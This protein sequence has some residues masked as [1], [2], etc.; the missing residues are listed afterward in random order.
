[1]DGTG[2]VNFSESTDMGEVLVVARRLAGG[3]AAGEL[4]GHETRFCMLRRPMASILD[5]IRLTSRIQSPR[6]GGDVDI[7]RV[8][9][10]G[11]ERHLNNWGRYAAFVDMPS[12]DALEL[13][14]EGRISGAV[15]LKMARLGDGATM[16]V[17]PRRFK[18][19]LRL[20]S[21]SHRVVWGGGEKATRVIRTVPN[22]W[23]AATTPNGHR[24]LE[25]NPGH[26]LVPDRIWLDNV[27]ALSLWCDTAVLSN[28][29]YAVRLD[30][31]PD[32]LDAHKAMCA[33]LNSIFGVVTALG[34][35]TDTRG[36]WTRLAIDR[37]REVR[38]PDISALPA[39][40]VGSLARV[41][42]RHASEDFG[43]LPDQFAAGGPRERFDTEVFGVLCG[44]ASAPGALRRVRPLYRM[45][46][47]TIAA[48]SRQGG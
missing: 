16:G 30:A 20:G 47:G 45:L 1:M 13:L 41:L 24:I 40:T 26:L 7:C 32:D 3:E 4:A 31:F 46:G 22:D 28:S 25:R 8:A 5:A 18:D 34:Q 29:F 38:V 39:G 48:L 6:G 15:R 10:A 2:R 44:D 35:R 17:V 27:H 23:C 14:E 19:S 33:W 9:R 43:R 21:G 11:L 42:D 37:W 12:P 36:K